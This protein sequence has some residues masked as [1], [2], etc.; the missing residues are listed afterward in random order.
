MPRMFQDPVRRP[1]NQRG[2]Y[3]GWKWPRDTQDGR[4]ARSEWSTAVRYGLG[5]VETSNGSTRFVLKNTDGL[6][7]MFLTT[8]WKVSE[9]IKDIIEEIDPGRHQFIPIKITD[10]GKSPIAKP[11]W[12]ILNVMERQE[13]IVDELSKVKPMYGSEDTRERMSISP[14]NSFVMMNASQLNRD[15]HLWR[16]KRYNIEIFISDD[17]AMRLEEIGG[18]LP[19]LT[20][21]F[22]KIH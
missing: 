20:V 5:M 18:K 17:L 3:E 19:F 13:S 4:V 9:R 7:D 8:F 14:F 16:E 21:D 10:K 1:Y 2:S 6:K 15:V 12:Y 22:V 11:N